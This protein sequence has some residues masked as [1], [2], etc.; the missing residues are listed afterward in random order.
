QTEPEPARRIDA[1][2]IGNPPRRRSLPRRL[3]TSEIHRR[4]GERNPPPVSAKGGNR[5][6]AIE[7][8]RRIGAG[9][10]GPGYPAFDFTTVGIHA[11]ASAREDL[12]RIADRRGS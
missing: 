1:A 3:R 5:G 7:P 12:A 11:R 9:A 6:H 4:V 2:A 8:A 10:A